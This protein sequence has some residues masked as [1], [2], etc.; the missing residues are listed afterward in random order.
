MKKLS[1]I[2]TDDILYSLIRRAV[3]TK[4]V[5]IN[6]DVYPEGD[7]PEDSQKEDIVINTIALTHDKPQDG[8]SNVNIYVADLRV[9]VH[10]KEQRAANRDR[11][12]AIGDDLVSFIEDQNL[13]DFEMWIESDTL[14]KDESARQH[15]RNLR[16]KWNIH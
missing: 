6:G 16:I 3:D 11:L 4:A 5:K 1:T 15:Y 8:T 10:G 9:K 7:R 14:L 13:A 12:Q 2:D